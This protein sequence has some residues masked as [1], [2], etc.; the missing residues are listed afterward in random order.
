MFYGTFPKVA[1]FFFQIYCFQYF[2][3]VMIV[4]FVGGATNFSLHTEYPA[5]YESGRRFCEYGM[6]YMSFIYLYIYACSE[7]V[8]LYE[9]FLFICIFHYDLF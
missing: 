2:T 5:Q 3:S 8:F 6:G 4:Y 1:F 9:I 7:S